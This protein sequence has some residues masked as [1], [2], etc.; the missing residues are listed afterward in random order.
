ML[1]TCLI[2]LA[3]NANFLHNIQK[4]VQ[5]LKPWYKADQHWVE[6]LAYLNTN[7]IEK[8]LDNLESIATLIPESEQKETLNVVRTSKK[9]KYIDD[10]IVVDF[11]QIT[12]LKDKWLIQREKF[13]AA[14][15]A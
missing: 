8:R 7:P 12:V 10:P 15:K 6:I 13:Y 14:I 4:L 1:N 5:F 2:A 9:I 3:K 11:A